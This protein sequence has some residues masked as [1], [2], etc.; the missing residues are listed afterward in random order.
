MVVVSES[1]F[2]LLYVSVFAVAALACFASLTRLQQITDSDTRWGLRALLLTSGGWATAHVGYLV[3]PTTSLKLGWYTIGLVVGLATVGAWLYFCSA[4]TGRTYHRNPTYRRLAVA[5]YIALTAVKLTNPLHQGY[6]TATAIATPFPHLSVYTGPLH[7][8][9]MGL[10]YAFAFVGYFMLLE[11]FT[12]IDLDTRA[13]FVLIGITA[14]PAVFDLIGYTTPFL[15]DMTYEPLGVAVFAVGVA[16]V[17]TDRLDA[18]Q[19]AAEQDD[20]VIALDVDKQIRDTNQA[21][22]TVFPDLVGAE[23][24][25]LEMTL[26]QVANCLGSDDPILTVQKEGNTRYYRVTEAPYGT[27]NT[28]L[29][30]TIVFT[31]VTDR[32][33][34]SEELKRQ[35]E[36]LERFASLVSHDLRNPLNVAQ[37]RFE[38]LREEAEV[39]ENNDH[40]A[41]VERSHSRMEELIE[42]I[43]TLARDGK[44]VDQWDAVLLS[45]AVEE[46][47]EMVDTGTAELRLE[48]D[49]TFKADEKRLQRLFENLFRNALDHAGPDVTV[50]VGA[51]PDRS[52]FYIS[53]DGP[54]IPEGD[55]ESV[56][57]P[58]YTT[59]KEGTGFGLAIVDEAVTAHGWEIYVTES[60]D[61][62]AR[63]EITGVQTLA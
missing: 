47:W 49:L 62:G 55:R 46:C 63:F 40:A 57:E 37:L 31:D 42:Q 56:L 1:L 18:V 32:E 35:N 51:L 19:L 53:D 23:G 9:A 6:F 33:Q 20:P 54:G 8:T 21:A 29:G 28:S 61:G 44:P 34:Y 25:Q 27:A 36:R 22:R 30:R 13:L 58:G 14:F 3:S 7:W 2:F 52:G 26:P 12:E 11:L 48:D 59:R 38:L 60:D 41:A 43:L 4:Y 15:L 39:P 10:S 5:V 24:T 17:Y 45:S 50:T 16:F